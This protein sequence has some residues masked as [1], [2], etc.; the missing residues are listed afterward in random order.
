MP[1]KTPTTDSHLGLGWELSRLCRA[2][3]HRVDS[4]VSQCDT[5]EQQQPSEPD[6]CSTTHV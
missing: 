6:S 1:Y 5:T 4:R 3:Q 2:T